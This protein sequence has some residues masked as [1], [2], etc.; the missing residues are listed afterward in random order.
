ME[1]HPLETRLCLEAKAT[2]IAIDAK[3]EICICSFEIVVN[4]RLFSL[5]W[6]VLTLDVSSTI[7]H[8][9]LIEFLN[10]TG[11]GQ[12]TLYQ[13]TMNNVNKIF[14]LKREK[15]NKSILNQFYR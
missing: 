10:R 6:W 4:V 1:K 12:D 9:Q 2:L 15:M 8:R 5:V 11:S 13:M 7:S 14:W 3:G